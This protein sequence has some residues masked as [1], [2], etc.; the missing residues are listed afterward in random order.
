MIPDP[1]LSYRLSAEADDLRCLRQD[2]HL[3]PSLSGDL[4]A[5]SF[6]LSKSVSRRYGLG[7]GSLVQTLYK[8]FRRDIFF[9]PLKL[10]RD[11]FD[12]RD[13]LAIVRDG[14][15]RSRRPANYLPATDLRELN[16]PLAHKVQ[17]R[18]VERV[19]QVQFRNFEAVTRSL[20][21]NPG[22]TVPPTRF[23]RLEV[24][25]DIPEEDASEEVRRIGSR[26][27]GMYLDV[28]EG[29]KPYVLKFSWDVRGGESFVVY[30]KAE[31][32]VRCEIR[33]S[34]KQ[35]RKAAGIWW[36]HTEIL[37]TVEAVVRKYCPY[38][39]EVID[40]DLDTTAPVTGEVP[41]ELAFFMA[42]TL[43]DL[44]VPFMRGKTGPAV[45]K[46][47]TILLRND[48]RI[49]RNQLK[50]DS[51]AQYVLYMLK[52]AGRLQGTK[53]RG[54]YYLKNRYCGLLR[55]Q[56]AEPDVSRAEP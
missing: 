20:L 48:G 22:L 18:A 4:E 56:R 54:S 9:N 33:V 24:A 29:K 49:R 53:K 34:G 7:Y 21:A 46:V 32:L 26:L 17:V 38:L 6:D 14:Q 43:L 52:N 45:R 44:G 8:A 39:R 28:K 11:Y 27:Q 2:P 35:V 30:A 15:R 3:R 42:D 50:G 13:I 19:A 5:D 1:G 40:A 37:S 16:Y 23:K 55:I 12:P 10:V 31:G 51:S 47:I 36:A 41:G 25:Y